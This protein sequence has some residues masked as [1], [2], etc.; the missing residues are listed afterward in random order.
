[1]KHSHYSLLALACLALIAASPFPDTASPILGQHTVQRGET[2]YCIGRSYGV[3]PSAIAEANGLSFSAILAV[4]QVLQIPAVQWANMPGGPVC[5][6]QFRSPFTNPSPPI[7]EPAVTT[8]PIPPPATATPA[9]PV[10]TISPV[11]SGS[12]YTVQRGDTL[13]RIGLRFGVTVA[14][15]KAANGLVGNTIFVRQVLVIPGRVNNSIAGGS[16]VIVTSTPALHSPTGGNQVGGYVCPD[17]Q[18]CILGNISASGERIYHFP[19]CPNYTQVE[20]EPSKGERVFAT[21]GEA[22][23]AGWRRAGNCP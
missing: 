16:V 5:A 14:S 17:G 22:E 11:V 8:V 15:L 18:L 9:P 13:F 20:I 10:T 12:T 21:A 6:P 7:T 3:F 19:G 23:A 4:G 2:L 1:M